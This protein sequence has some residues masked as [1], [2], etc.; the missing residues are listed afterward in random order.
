MPDSVEK[1]GK[2][3]GLPKLDV[4]RQHIENLT[5]QEVA[6]YCLRD[7][8]IVLRGL[9]YIRDTFK[10]V[11]ADFAYTLASISTRWVRRSS[12]IE[13]M[14]FYE[15]DEN[16]SYIYS[17]QQLK[18][19]EFCLPA[20]FGGRVEVIKR[21]LFKKKLF[22]YD[23][24][25]SY[26]WSMTQV[27]PLYFKGFYPPPRDTP[28]ALEHCGISDA[29]VYIPKGTAHLPILPLRHDGKL[30]FPE[31]TIK[32]R[33]T[34]IELKQLWERYRGKGI[35][36]SIHGQARFYELSF[37]KP[38]IDLFYELR[39]RAKEQNDDFQVYAYK[40]LLNSLYG[41]L[42]ENIDRKSILYGQMVNEAIE[43]HGVDKITATAIPGVFAL[44]TQNR[45][46][47]RHVAAGCYVTAYSRLRLL[48]GM[49]TCLNAGGKIYYC[50]TDSIVT[51][52]E[53]K[54]FGSGN[55]GDF[56]LES[57]ISEAE[58]VSPKVYRMITIKGEEIY[59]VKGMPIKGLTEQEK[60]LRWDLYNYHLNPDCKERVDKLLLSEED[61]EKYSSKEGIAGFMTDLNK[62]RLDPHIHLLKRQ[63]KNVDTKREHIGENSFPLF[64]DQSEKEISTNKEVN[65]NGD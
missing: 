64:V 39:R 48:E 54:D 56:K 51:D 59:K 26:P 6:E 43:K 44:H 47:F 60:R 52:K 23:I 46:P 45:G 12:V 50:D 22:Y 58:F 32:G 25:S 4:D 28:D 65:I 38:F 8:D 55:L 49:E 19:D 14:K 16:G 10:K 27:L 11:D 13:W 34:N 3:V 2:T 21:G 18:A 37:L 9:Q 33:W 40:I 36:I 57:E 30:I 61:R 42:V 5:I 31:G 1:I 63:L 41:K 24:T 62:G 7:C 17:K 15:Q 20:Y 29:T 35:K 53:I